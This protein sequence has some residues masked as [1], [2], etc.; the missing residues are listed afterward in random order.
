L[1]LTRYKEVLALKEELEKYERGEDYENAN[2]VV[3]EIFKIF[4]EEN[5]Y[6]TS[7]N[8]NSEGL[9]GSE[10]SE[11]AQSIIKKFFVGGRD[12]ELWLPILTLISFF[13][14]SAPSQHTQ[15]RNL[16]PLENIIK[17][18]A[19]KMKERITENVTESRD[20]VL[21]D[22]LR[23]MVNGE[24]WEDGFVPVKTIKTAMSASFD[25]E[26]KWLSNEWI[27]RAMR[28]F[29]FVDKRRIGTGIEY[30]ITKEKVLD[31]AKKYLQQ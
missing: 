22:T 25:E 18:V 27:G 16:T 19:K 17:W 15:Q 2:E 7:D 14:I 3:K 5:I 26:Q 29:G 11:G 24:N 4:K 30:R 12:F 28:R 21:I 9:R 31:L 13:Y 23:K 10:G 1:F 6:F 8:G 20:V